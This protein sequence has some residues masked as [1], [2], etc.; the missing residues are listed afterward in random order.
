MIPVRTYE[1]LQD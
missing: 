1:I